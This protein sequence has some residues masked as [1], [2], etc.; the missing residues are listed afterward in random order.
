M[1][2]KDKEPQKLSLAQQD[3]FKRLGKVEEE[4]RKPYKKKKEPFNFRAVLMTLIL[5]LVL[6]LMIGSLFLR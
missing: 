5:F 2:E 6:G 3:A 4:K 1:S